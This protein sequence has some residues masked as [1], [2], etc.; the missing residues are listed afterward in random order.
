MNDTYFKTKTYNTP[1]WRNLVMCQEVGH[2]VGLA[3]QDEDFDN[4]NLGTCMDY[5]RLPD[6]NQHPNQHDY[7][8]LETIYSHLDG[9]TTIGQTSDTSTGDNEPGDGPRAW[10][11]EIFRSADGRLSVFEK[12]LGNDNKKV[13]HVFWT[14]ERA[15]E[16]RGNQDEHEE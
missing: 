4:G 11:K 9:S 7:D 8:E 6:S 16:H 14:E 12:D 1:A 5:T 2:T 15:K 13:T 3:H 10:G